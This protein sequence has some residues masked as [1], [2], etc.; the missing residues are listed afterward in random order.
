LKIERSDLELLDCRESG[1][2]SVEFTDRSNANDNEHDAA[3]LSQTHV[4]HSE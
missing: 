1:E 3:S 4:L 2:D